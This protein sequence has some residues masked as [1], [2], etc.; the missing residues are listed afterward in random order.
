MLFGKP[1]GTLAIPARPEYA[2]QLQDRMETAHALARDKL[3]KASVRQKWNCDVRSKGRNFEAVQSV[4][5]YSLKKK[6]GRSPKLDC[7]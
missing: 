1:P 6:R 4:W 3:G 5:L 2:R 7:H